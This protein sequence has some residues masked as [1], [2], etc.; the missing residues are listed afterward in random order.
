MIYISIVCLLLIYLCFI[1]IIIFNIY[2]YLFVC[3]LVFLLLFYL[4]CHL[5]CY[6]FFVFVFLLCLLLA[7][8]LSTSVLLHRLIHQGPAVL[9]PATEP[10]RFEQQGVVLLQGHRGVVLRDG[11]G[12]RRGASSAEEARSRADDPVVLRLGVGGRG[13]SAGYSLPSLGCL[14]NTR[15]RSQDQLRRP[16]RGPFCSSCWCVFFIF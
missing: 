13:A 11:V 14:A 15:P 2:T 3:L 12:G 8:V 1:V 10:V 16:L 5:Y 7:N 4:C 6:V 9:P